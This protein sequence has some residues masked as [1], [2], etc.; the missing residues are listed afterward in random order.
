[1]RKTS[2]LA[3][4][5]CGTLLLL[6]LF[7]AGRTLYIKNYQQTLEQVAGKGVQDMLELSENG[8]SVATLTDR[9]QIDAILSMLGSY[10]YTE[11][12]RFFRPSADE[13]SSNRLTVSF[14]NGRSISVDADG[15]IFL[16]GKLRD[17]KGSR[18]QEF[19]HK[20]YVL[21][22]PTAA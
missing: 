15:H 21:F 13:F 22:Y 10:V 17:I 7:V 9:A 16:D 3:F 20:L 6:L 4:A 1:M 19:Y 2:A 18:G 14:K 11:F 12:P 8:V 5:L